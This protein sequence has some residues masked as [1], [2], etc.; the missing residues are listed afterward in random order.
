MV[1]V[2]HA[3]RVLVQGQHNSLGRSHQRATAA[4]VLE[5]HPVHRGVVPAPVLGDT[6]H[7]EPR[8][9]PCVPEQPSP[10]LG[11]RRH[12]IPHLRR[13]PPPEAPQELP[14]KARCVRQKGTPV[15]EAGPGPHTANT[16]PPPHPKFP[17]NVVPAVLSNDDV[18]VITDVIITIATFAV[19]R[20]VGLVIGLVNVFSC[21]CS[22]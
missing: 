8:E 16:D 5:L 11:R 6:R 14:G 3:A 15:A 4:G 17:H 20:A 9:H 22:Y 18:H 2:L 12:A 10:N 21:T 7:H 13:P 19:N 1:V